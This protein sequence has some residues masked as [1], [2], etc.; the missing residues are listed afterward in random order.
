MAT[1]PEELVRLHDELVAF[2][3]KSKDPAIDESL[4]NLEHVANAVGKAW[5]GSWLGYHASVYYKTFA[6]PP[7][8]EHF[9]QEWGL[10]DMYGHGIADE[11]PERSP[12]DVQKMIFTKA[13]TPDLS[14]VKEAAKAA[15]AVFEDKRGT[16]V[17]ILEVFLAQ[18]KDAFVERLRDEVLK[19]KAYTASDFVSMKRPSGNLISRDQLAISQG[20]KVPPHISVIAETFG[21][22]S[23]LLACEMLAKSAARA[24]EH[25]GRV[26]HQPKE[27]RHVGNRIFIGHGKSPAWSSFKDF[28]QDRLKLPWDEFNRVPVAGVTNVARLSEMLDSA[29]IAFLIMTA[30]D[31]NAAGKLQARMNVIHEAGLF[32]G[33]LG[34]TRAIILLEEGCEE[35]SNIHGLGQIRF[36]KGKIQA[37]FEEVRRV[38]E[39]EKVLGA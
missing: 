19:E 16:L 20:L 10:M 12:D 23:P 17:S 36:P 33:R 13:G 1:L 8:G 24:A 3:E 26:Q 21:L 30:E 4:R 6:A 38:L 14:P 15:R 11:W 7:P 18:Q 31:E 25:I 27:A 9:S 37:C 28:I 32:Q 35:F 34:F 5:S 2:I 39:R 22:R 29:T